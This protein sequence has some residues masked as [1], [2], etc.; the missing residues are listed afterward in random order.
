MKNELTDLDPAIWRP[1]PIAPMP[2]LA[3]LRLAVL[4]RSTS[5]IPKWKFRAAPDVVVQIQPRP[6]SVS[7]INK[8][9][10]PWFDGRAVIRDD[11]TEATLND[12]TRDGWKINFRVTL[13][14]ASM[15]WVFKIYG[16]GCR[17]EW[18]SDAIT[19][20]D[21]LVDL[22]PV[23]FARLRP[24]M[25]LKPS[26]LMCGKALTDPVS[27]ARWIGPECAGTTSRSVPYTFMLTAED[28]A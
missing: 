28:A 17:E 20:R 10:L 26:C 4:T 11:A 3:E 23:A 1:V 18:R 24:E 2:L 12:P 7:K 15:E 25:M 8:D 16:V 5:R 22:M 9:G 19:T 6:A 21:R 27:M 14:Y 13:D